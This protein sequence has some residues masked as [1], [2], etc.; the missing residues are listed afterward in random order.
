MGVHAAEPLAAKPCKSF[1]AEGTSYEPSQHV[2]CYG[3]ILL[4]SN[5]NNLHETIVNNSVA[6]QVDHAQIMVGISIS[7][8]IN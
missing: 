4:K 2:L 3:L 5:F 8:R 7:R 1:G 6:R